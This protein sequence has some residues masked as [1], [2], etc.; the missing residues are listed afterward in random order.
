MNRITS[1]RLSLLLGVPFSAIAA[2]TYYSAVIAIGSNG[3][4]AIPESW[5]VWAGITIIALASSAEYR[6]L[7][8]KP[9]APQLSPTRRI[10]L[11]ALYG[12]LVAALGWL[13]GTWAAA[14]THPFP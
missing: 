5:S 4:Y 8:R 3:S 13:I 2:F 1:A 11:S 9:I 12:V 14:F 6:T 7:G 10:A